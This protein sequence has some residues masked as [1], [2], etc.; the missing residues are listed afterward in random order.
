M[1]GPRLWVRVVP[2]S[3]AVREGK[4]EARVKE[5][6]RG[7]RREGERECVDDA[8][9]LNASRSR[10]GRGDADRDGHSWLQRHGWG[11]R[12]GPNERLDRKSVV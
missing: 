11:I 10:A 8:I 9:G 5:R 4:A 12:N 6:G 2:K 1:V 3:E 7:E